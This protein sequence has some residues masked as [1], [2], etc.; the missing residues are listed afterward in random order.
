MSKLKKVLKKVLTIKMIERLYC[1][2]VFQ[3]PYCLGF[4]ISN[5]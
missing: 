3:V 4:V 5:G 2:N 1:T